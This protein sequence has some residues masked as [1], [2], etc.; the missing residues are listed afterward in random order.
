MYSMAL[1]FVRAILNWKCCI[2][3][4]QY[5][6][7]A[8][9]ILR[10]LAKVLCYEPI[11]NEDKKS[12]QM[13]LLADLIAC[14]IS[15]V[16]M[17]VA[18]KNKDALMEECMRKREEME[19]LRGL[20]DIISDGDSDYVDM[21]DY[22]KSTTVETSADLGKSLG[23]VESDE[24]EWQDYDEDD[25]DYTSSV[26]V[27]TLGVLTESVAVGEDDDGES[28]EIVGAD[29][30]TDQQIQ[31]DVGEDKAVVTDRTADELEMDRLAKSCSRLFNTDVPFLTFARIL[32][33]LFCLIDCVSESTLQCPLDNRIHRAIYVK[34]EEVARM[35][36]PKQ[37]TKKVQDVI[38]VVAGKL[39]K[40]VRKSLQDAEVAFLENNPPQVES[41]ELRDWTKRLTEMTN[42][43]EDWSGW[44]E[45]VVCEACKL[46]A[47]KK[48]TRGEWWEWTSKFEANA[49][50]WR[51]T[52]LEAV[53]DEHHDLMM[54][55]GREVVKT[56]DKRKL[57]CHG[58]EVVMNKTSFTSC[59]RFVD[60]ESRSQIEC[61]RNQI[62]SR[63]LRSQ[64]E[65]NTRSYSLDIVPGSSEK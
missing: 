65:S 59:R 30:G 64:D 28:I 41:K 29:D 24:E 2:P 58:S 17:E 42:V 36:N 21:D 3:H 32:E 45:K 56:G 33:V 49:M 13:R 6:D 63:S 1:R 11:G 19:E 62:E 46:R 23:I 51:R 7:I 9:V 61:L 14:W 34:L 15:D 10:R 27:G 38:D 40:F 55:C 12:Q 4:E 25:G 8:A 37:L 31:T 50:L 54:V 60:T 35:E 39:A 26:G 44:L 53:H 22:D 20:E 47:K 52:Y 5:K 18:E 16:L 43:V 57:P 48:V